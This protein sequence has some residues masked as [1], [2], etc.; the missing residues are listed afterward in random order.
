MGNPALWIG[1]NLAV[2]LLLAL[3]LG[4]INR[5]AHEISIRAALVWSAVWVTLSLCFCLW[6]YSAHGR[7]PA[8]QFLTGYLIEKS[9]SVDNI[10]LFVLLFGYFGIAPRYQHRVL[11]WGILG[12]LVMRGAM[13]GLGTALIS[14]FEWLL[15]LFGAFLL[16][17]G[18]RMFFQKDMKP[19]PERNP[20]VRAARKLFPVTN[21][22]RGQH[23]LVREEGRWA[24]TPLLLALLVIESTDI[25]FALDSIPA[26]FSVTRDPFI[27]YTSNVCAILGLRAFYFLLAGVLPYF[28]YLGRGLAAVLVLVG[29]KMICAKWVDVPTFATLAGVAAMLTIATVASVLAARR[30]SSQKLADTGRGTSA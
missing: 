4:V 18:A 5:R 27:V 17:A 3:D 11:Y 29:L 1:F 26:V 10:F 2:L 13:I 21:E 8:L 19:Q 25:A 23:L 15:Y 9:L 16:F 20:L 24:A 7:E 14:R 22:A 12:A 28:R 6:I 30:E